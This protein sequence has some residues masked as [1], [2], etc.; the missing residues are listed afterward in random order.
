VDAEILSEILEK[1]PKAKFICYKR[2]LKRRKVFI[3]HYEK[4][5]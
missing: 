3:E 5:E 4:L 2:A 1:F